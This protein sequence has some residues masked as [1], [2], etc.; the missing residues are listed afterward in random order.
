MNDIEHPE[1]PLASPNR[2]CA[3][4]AMPPA[5][6]RDRR[7]GYLLGLGVLLV[8]A[9]AARLRRVG[10][11][12]RS[13]AEVA[14]ATAEQHRDFVPERPRGGGAGERPT[15]VIVSLPAT[16]SAFASANIFARASGY[17]DK[18]KVDIGDRVKAGQLLAQIIAP[19]LD[20]QIAQAQAT[21]AQLQAAVQQAQANRDLA[22]VTWNRDSPLVK[23]GL[24]D[25]AAGRPSTSRP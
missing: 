8:L 14:M 25:A 9:G 24:G 1:Q 22:Q 20:H 5:G 4:A 13:S 10:A 2:P 12:R 23:Q 6:A 19:E 15:A 17:I 21:L 3:R 7:Q 18:R 11:T 16:T